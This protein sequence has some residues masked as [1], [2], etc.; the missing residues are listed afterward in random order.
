MHVTLAFKFLLF[1]KL[2]GQPAFH[3]PK[4]KI[5]HLCGIYVCRGNLGIG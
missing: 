3:L 5:V 4:P 2:F 1:T